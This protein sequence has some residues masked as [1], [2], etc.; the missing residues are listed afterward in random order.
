MTQRPVPP[1][2]PELVPALTLYSAQTPP[3]LSLE[4][5]LGLRGQSEA[6]VYEPLMAQLADRGLVQEQRMIPGLA[7]DP[8]LAIGILRRRD[9]VAGGPG[10]YA[11]HGGGMI[12]GDERAAYPCVADWV[13]EFDAVAVSVDYRLAPEHLDPAPINDCYAGLL[14]TAAHADELGFDADR[15]IVQ[16]TSAGGGLAA[17]T[18]LMARD[19]GGPALAGQVLSC[20]MLDDRNDTISSRQFDG[21][22]TWDRGS[23]AVGW[24]AYLGSRHGTDDV[25]I[26]AA[27]ARAADLSSLPPTFIDVGSAELFRDESVAYAAKIWAAGGVAECHVFAGGYHGYDFFVPDAVVSRATVDARLSFIRRIFGPAGG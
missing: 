4:A 21:I 9:H 3:S 22:G 8:D 17:G 24:S 25:S 2:D 13:I 15:L 14:W 27:P 10:I 18:V 16:G 1:F 20:P 6:T 5:M 7:G 23:N 26:Y 12:M 19:L 11:I